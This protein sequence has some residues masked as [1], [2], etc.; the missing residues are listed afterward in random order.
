MPVAPGWARVTSHVFWKPVSANVFPLLPR[1]FQ[2]RFVNWTWSFEFVPM[3]SSLIA[4]T[5][6]GS[7]LA[8]EKST[9]ERRIE[10]GSASTTW[11]AVTGFAPLKVSVQ[12]VRLGFE[13]ID[14]SSAPIVTWPESRRASSLG[15][16]S[17]PPTTWYFSFDGP[18]LFSWP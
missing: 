11:S 7:K 9:D 6:S 18:K 14:T 2:W 1:S 4:V 3:P 15:T 12:V 13:E 10:N 16:W 17:F 8:F 5:L